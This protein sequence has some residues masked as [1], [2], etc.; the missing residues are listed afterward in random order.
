MI[1]NKNTVIKIAYY[2][3]ALAV[4][5]FFVVMIKMITPYFP[6]QYRVG[7]LT[8]K[9]DELLQNKFYLAAFYVH[10]TSS[11]FALGIGIFQFWPA[12]IRKYKSV[13]RILGIEAVNFFLTEKK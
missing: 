10:I 3:L 12:F 11:F 13:H 7:F 8:T 5:Y 1:S 6:Y 4:I 9:A 2:L